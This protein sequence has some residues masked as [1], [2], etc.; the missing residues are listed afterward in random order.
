MVPAMTKRRVVILAGVPLALLLLG[1]GFLQLRKWWYTGYS[2][3]SRTGVIR[4]ISVKGSP[5]CKYLSGEMVLMATNA[6][7]GNE[8]WEFTVD[9]DRPENPVVKKLHEAERA[10]KPVTVDYRQDLGNK[11]KMWVC[12]PTDYYVTGV[13]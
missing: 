3:G 9:D 7:Q 10:A 13:E 12:A 6:V 4:K 8:V 2:R 5:M 11:G 1:F